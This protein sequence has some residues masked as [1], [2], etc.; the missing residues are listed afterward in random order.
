MAEVGRIEAGLYLDQSAF[1]KGL[2]QA[3]GKANKF[4]SALGS[5]LK[6]GAAAGIAATATA[7]IGGTKAFAT[8]EQGLA[9]VSKTTGLTGTELKNL[10]ND[11]RALSTQGP[12]TVSALEDIA[13]AAGSLGVGA[14][15]MASGDIAGARAEIVSFT[16]TMSDMSVAFEMDAGVVATSMA[17]IG[18]VFKIPTENL[19]ILGSQ[20]N[21]LENTMNATAPGIIDFM[22]A[23]GGTATMWGESEA[24]TAAF[25][26]T[27]SSLGVKGPE[28]AT[29]IRSGLAT[30][31]SDGK[32]MQAMAD[33]MGISTTELSR[34]MNED[35]Y[36][37]LID[38]G[39]A[40]NGIEGDVEKAAAATDIFGTYGYQA[41]AKLGGGADIYAQALKNVN[42]TGNE[43]A[44]EAG[45]MADTL[46][47]QWQ[48]MK[49][50]VFDVGISIGEVTE[51]PV[52]NFLNTLNTSVIPA[53]K[54]FVVALAAGDVDWRGMFGKLPGIVKTAFKKAV[55]GAKTVWSGLRGIANSVASWLRAVDWGGVWDTVVLGA[56]TA[57]GALHD[58][59][60]YIL[61]GFQS[62]D[63]GGIWTE[64]RGIGSYIVSSLKS[65]DWSSIASTIG[66]GLRSAF[67]TLT[68][69][70]GAV[71][72][73]LKE[74]DWRGVGDTIIGLIGQGF[75]ALSGIGSK[76]FDAITSYD[77]S[78]LSD[79][80]TSG[81]ADVGGAIGS[82]IKEKLAA[83]SWGDVGH[84]ILD[85]IK[86]VFGAARDLGDYLAEAIRA[87]DWSPVGEKIAEWLKEGV[88]KGW[89]LLKWIGEKISGISTSD[90]TD[91]FS[92]W[93]N[94]VKGAFSE[95]WSGFSEEMTGGAGWKAAFIELF[96]EAFDYV[97]GLLGRWGSEIKNSIK[98]HL[99]EIL[100]KVDLWTIDFINLWIYAANGALDSAYNFRD[101]ISPIFDEAVGAVTKKLD[102]VGATKAFEDLKAAAEAPIATVK[103]WV[104]AL[105]DAIQGLID[106]ASN[107]A[108]VGGYLETLA[109]TLGIGAQWYE[110]VGSSGDMGGR[111][112]MTE[113]EKAAWEEEHPAWKLRVSE[114]QT[115]FSLPTTQTQVPGIP[116]AEVSLS[117]ENVVFTTDQG[118]STATQGQL[119]YVDYSKLDQILE[120]TPGYG[121]IWP[122]GGW[123]T[124]LLTGTG[125]ADYSALFGEVAGSVIRPEG[126]TYLS[127]VGSLGYEETLAG[128]QDRLEYKIDAQTDELT[129]SW[130]STGDAVHSDLEAMRAEEAATAASVGSIAG[131]IPNV[132]SAT[133]ETAGNTA[134]FPAG[135][136][137]ISSQI[138][139]M[140]ANLQGWLSRSLSSSQQA[141]GYQPGQILSREEVAGFA[142]AVRYAISP[143]TGK[144]TAYIGSA[145]KELEKLAINGGEEIVGAGKDL[146]DSVYVSSNYAS[147]A[148]IGSTQQSSAIQLGGA[149][150]RND[151]LQI[152]TR[153]ANQATIDTSNAVS[154]SQLATNETVT[155]GWL[156]SSAAA[157]QNILSG[158]QSFFG[159]I[160]SSGNI[161]KD[162]AD[163]AA[164]NQK[165]ASSESGATWNTAVDNSGQTIQTAADAIGNAGGVFIG[166]MGSLMSSL[167]RV[168]G[169]GGGVTYTAGGGTTSGVGYS[170]GG[171]DFGCDICTP[172]HGY[173]AL[174]YTS[175]SGET[176]AINPMTFQSVGGISG[177][178]SSGAATKLTTS[179]SSGG[180]LSY[181]SGWLK[182]APKSQ[183]AIVTNYG[184]WGSYAEG[185]V[186]VGPQLAVVGDNPS[187]REAIIPEEV[188]GGKGGPGG[189]QTIII[190]LDG[191]T[192]GRAVGSRM[193]K[194]I[195]VKTGR[196]FK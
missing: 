158:G 115:N 27:L 177:A 175:P 179:K 86:T 79:R 58:L 25:G 9:S 64:L 91:T 85:G 43:L 50:S 151:I 61:E 83:V 13:G 120:G 183:K 119:G 49:N 74:I 162:A 100:T 159:D 107:V 108:N 97:V 24:A 117:G 187:G 39:A 102:E 133:T 84:R 40:M 28:A 160:Y 113:A 8:Y 147:G 106:T 90:A 82:Y 196:N 104:D 161:W 185:G 68:D 75:G 10:G 156:S 101:W 173:N 69:L 99:A 32:K 89:D 136:Q 148:T 21:A 110:S 188:W 168:V 52:K 174:I 12:V 130:K 72:E 171:E 44:A 73:K 22:N 56:Y 47:G 127:P 163:W 36:G 18:N 182:S 88:Q 132:A 154:L 26:A 38:M 184:T 172:M 143:D 145:G 194:Q 139:S 124:K 81:L 123:L 42:V 67:E 93:F 63:W 87:Y 157:R 76:L 152:G 48:R 16:K 109:S 134:A 20:I 140:P 178:I 128:W 111:H 189:D 114:N 15:K 92:G 144:L 176:Y 149:Y 121:A 95:F 57:F 116:Q 170:A 167:A 35:L 94:A 166:S 5:A 169:S 78:S 80:I 165:T 146:A 142:N 164:A 41:L 138:A 65:V 192:I 118:T 31:T 129:S 60:D 34:R 51:G 181:S 45:V 3:E 122:Q 53:V 191:K 1:D 7:V 98:G 96:W 54:D 37:A 112:F 125:N 141:Q 186:A 195:V 11:L 55:A 19:N 29:A 71:V 2:A 6:A 131:T 4:G 126:R 59:G 46:T 77:W 135:L 137:S 30:I 155:S 103:G 150:Q 62:I 70:G 33:I 105:K 193:A 153:Q 17:D 23:F 14:A 180:S 190:Q 66:S